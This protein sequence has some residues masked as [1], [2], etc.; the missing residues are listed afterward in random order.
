MAAKSKQ[1][2]IQ[3]KN[4]SATFRQADHK[5]IPLPRQ[6]YGIDFYG[7]EKGETVVLTSNRL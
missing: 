3:R 5:D 2:S 6:A 1:A 7:H 4:L